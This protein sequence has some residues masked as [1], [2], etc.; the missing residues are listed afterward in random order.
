MAV[1]VAAGAATD[2]GA[3]KFCDL[4]FRIS[5]TFNEQP[6]QDAPAKAQNAFEK[7]LNAVLTKAEKV[8]PSA[9][10]NEVTTAVTA[11]KDDLNRAFEDPAVGEAVGAIDEWAVENCGYEVVD[12]SLVDYAFEGVPDT[13]PTGKSVFNL[14]NDGADSH[15]MI[16][17]RL[18]TDTPLDELLALD[19]DEAEKQ[20]EFIAAGFAEPGDTGTAYADLKKPGRYA[21]ACFIPTGTH[22][23]VEGDGPPHFAQGMTAEFTVEKA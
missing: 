5:Q 14:T 7:K 9:I 17:F 3:K 1:P 13:M 18:K 6:D 11:L 4:N 10:S 19:Q 16:V 23:D 15:E 21:A 2:S 22:G 20:I 8:A 12:V